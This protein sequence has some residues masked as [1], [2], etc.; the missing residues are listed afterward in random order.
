[1][2]GFSGENFAP[3]NRTSEQKPKYGT[4][5]ICFTVNFQTTLYSTKQ[6]TETKITKPNSKIKFNN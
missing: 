4:R 3:L 6:N 2:E 1:M 5:Y